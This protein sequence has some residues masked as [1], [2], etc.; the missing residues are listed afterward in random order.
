VLKVWLLVLAVA[1]WL[2]AIDL[3]VHRLPDRIVLPAAVAVALHSQSLRSLAGGAVLVTAYAVLAILPRSAL[4][5]GDVKLAGLLGTALA[6]IGW[7]PLVWGTALAFV[8]G[9]AVA[10]VLLT[11]GRARRDTQL[12]FGPA[13]LAGGLLAALLA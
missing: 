6:R 4:G 11:S 2:C 7:A 9:G 3:A 10:I 8:L 13:M 12:P 1:P 5:F